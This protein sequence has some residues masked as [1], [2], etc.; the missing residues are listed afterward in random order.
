MKKI[1]TKRSVSETNKIYETYKICY[2]LFSILIFIDIV[3]KFNF[4]DYLNVFPTSPQRWVEFWIES[5]IFVIIFFINI[6]T[7][8]RKGITIGTKGLPKDV[9]QKHRYASISAIIGLIISVSLWILIVLASIGDDWSNFFK[10]FIL[11]L[12]TFIV[13]FSVLYLTFFIAYK[14]AINYNNTKKI[15]KIN[16]Q[17]IIAD[18]IEKNKIYRIS[19]F[20]F[21]I[22][23]FIDIIVKF[24]VQDFFT[25]QKYW[26]VEFG[27]KFGIE[28]VLLIIIFYTNIIML[29]VQGITIG[30]GDLPKDTFHKRRYA[31]IS[32]KAGLIVAICLS[33]FSLIRWSIDWDSLGVI[34]YLIFIILIFIPTFFIS[35]AMF[36][37]GYKI[38]LNYKNMIV[39]NE[40]NGVTKDM[41]EVETIS[42]DSADTSVK[43]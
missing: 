34:I 37:I 40:L 16:D 23:I 33:G 10:C 13:V 27:I 11:M 31:S 38:A 5:I 21:L 22:F 26:W 8:A 28:F 36:Y 20:L 6:I 35:Y 18:N 39:V 24:N 3:I 14:I 41:K 25:G 17:S 15:N 9:F 12:S 2:Y 43:K 29:A 7:L 4:Y 19:Y 42:T 30:T 32:A 1:K